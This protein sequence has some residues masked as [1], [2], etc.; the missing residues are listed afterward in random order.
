M[1]IALP[2]KNLDIKKSNLFLTPLG[3]SNKDSKKRW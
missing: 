3:I 2:K 1:P